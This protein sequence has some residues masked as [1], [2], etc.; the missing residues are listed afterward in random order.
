MILLDTSVLIE[1]FRVKDKSKTLFFRLSASDD[2]FGVSS[3]THYEIFIGVPIM[4]TDFW[5]TF[6]EQVKIIPFDGK[7]SQEA[8]KIYKE[9]KV[10]NKLVA[11]P[12]LLIAATAIANRLP[13]ATLNVKHFER[14]EKLV[15][16]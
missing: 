14:I 16:L 7:C 5:T 4:Q 10:K 9:L 15:I 13:V 8:V 1:L 3:I 6:F 11:L 2:K 12:D